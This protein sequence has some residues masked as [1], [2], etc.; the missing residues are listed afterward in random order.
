M[1]R[2]QSLIRACGDGKDEHR[3]AG[4]ERAQTVTTPGKTCS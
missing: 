3:Q 4:H 1:R 2:R